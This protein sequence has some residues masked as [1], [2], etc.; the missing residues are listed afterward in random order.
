MTVC[1]PDCLFLDYTGHIYVYTSLDSVY[2]AVSMTVSG[3]DRLGP[4]YTVHIYVYTPPDSV[5]IAVSMTVSGPDCISL[6]CH[7]QGYADCHLVYSIYE[8]P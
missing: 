1:G 6:D 4:D 5:Y 8:S 3:P 2:C 7:D